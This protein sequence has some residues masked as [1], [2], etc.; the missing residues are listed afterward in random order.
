MFDATGVYDLH[1]LLETSAYDDHTGGFSGANVY[2]LPALAA[3]L[4]VARLGA[5]SDLRL[6]KKVLDWLAGKLDVP[7]AIAFQLVDDVEYLLTSAVDGEPASKLVSSD[8]MTSEIAEKFLIAAA[9]EIRRMHEIDIESC[10]LDQQLDAKLDLARKNI[11]NKL[12][13]DTDAE[14]AQ[15]HDGKLPEHVYRELIA[16]RPDTEDLVFTHGDLC[17]PNIMVRDGSI[18][19]FVDMAGAGVGDRYT[20]IA[21]FFRSFRQN[22]DIEIELE[23]IFCEAYDLEISDRR[24]LEFYTLLDDLF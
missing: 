19:G 17:L 9:R 6:E 14:F 15:E 21:I 13:S 3:Y 20:D 16:A 5:A 23:S 12:L 24:K 2:H 22:C 4:K 8:D 7:K 1:V 11:Q 18:S 10:P